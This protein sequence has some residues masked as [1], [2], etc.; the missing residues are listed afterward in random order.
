MTILY[1]ELNRNKLPVS[2]I[3]LL[4]DGSLVLVVA[5][6]CYGLKRISRENEFKT[7]TLRNFRTNFNFS[8]YQERAFAEY[9]FTSLKF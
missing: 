8:A 6:Q 5:L 9:L 1:V 4:E 7:W 2:F 3:T